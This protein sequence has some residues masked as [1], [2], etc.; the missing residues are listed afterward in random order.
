VNGRIIAEARKHHELLASRETVQKPDDL[1]PP[2][3]T[4]VGHLSRTRAGMT[5]TCE[6]ALGMTDIAEQLQCLLLREI[7]PGYATRAP[8]CFSRHLG[9]RPRM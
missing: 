2:L 9:P 1:S 8:E 4:L 3:S 6:Y 7:V 5:R